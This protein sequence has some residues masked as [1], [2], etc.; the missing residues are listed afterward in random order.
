M[1]G[2]ATA[3]SRRA[4]PGGARKR[5]AGTAVVL[6]AAGALIA[7]CS[8]GAPEPAP[9]DTGEPVQSPGATTAP[10][11]G[12]PTPTATGSASPTPTP[13]PEI[14]E[15]TEDDLL[16]TD[17]WQE[18]E[19]GFIEFEYP[20]GWD[21][22]EASGPAAAWLMDVV[23]ENGTVLA[24]FTPEPFQGDADGPIMVSSVA[25]LGRLSVDTEA[26]AD[27]VLLTVA[28]EP[29]ES[30]VEKERKFQVSV[31]EPAQ[32]DAWI[33]DLQSP[34]GFKQTDEDWAYFVSAPEFLMLDGEAVQ[35]PTDEQIAEFMGTER[36]LQLL[37]VLDSLG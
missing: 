8:G 12:S 4:A 17:G 21:V 19:N 7:G 18:F 34:L 25:E 37:T 33:A 22:V 15:I 28:T 23:D 26:E 5:A 29:S 27:Q 35:D 13:A 30:A 10:A 20:Q 11:T 6:A 16:E 24:Q 1:R 14:P 3:G 9:T 2:T 36:Y 32:A 31:L